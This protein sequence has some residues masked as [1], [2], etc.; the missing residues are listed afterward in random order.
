M[1]LLIITTNKR[2]CTQ[3][4]I[5]VLKIITQTLTL[6]LKADI[7]HNIMRKKWLNTAVGESD[8]MEIRRMLS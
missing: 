6:I 1:G 8:A 7:E 5:F 3:Q 2:I 4:L